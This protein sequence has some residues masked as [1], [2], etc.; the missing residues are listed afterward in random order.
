MKIAVYTTNYNGE[1][2]LKPFLKHYESFCHKIV[3]YDNG[4]NDNSEAIVKAH[5]F[6]QWIHFDDMLEIV[7]ISNTCWK[8]DI[9]YDYCIF[10]DNDEFLWVN[11]SMIE[12][13][14]QKKKEGITVMLPQG[15]TIADNH[16]PVEGVDWFEQYPRGFPFYAMDKPVIFNPTQIQ[17]NAQAGGHIWNRDGKTWGSIPT[18][19]VVWYKSKGDLKL[20]HFKQLSYDYWKERCKISL[21]RITE[22]GAKALKQ[23]GVGGYIAPY[24]ETEKAGYNAS[25]DSLRRY[26]E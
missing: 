25:L 8:D 24:N 13:L 23:I 15:W 18:G 26:D 4:S 7:N 6:A 3:I 19:N 2:I 16:M 14:E 20:L 17:R 11:G 22:A 21:D 10:V 5:P 1:V 12:F 9:D